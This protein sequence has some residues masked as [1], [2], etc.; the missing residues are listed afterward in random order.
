MAVVQV[1][2][3][4]LIRHSVPENFLVSSDGRPVIAASFLIQLRQCKVDLTCPLLR[5]YTLQL[6]D[7]TFHNFDINISKYL[8]VSA[9]KNFFAF[10][11]A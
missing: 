4:Q 8:T 5:T 2:T 10:K 9:Y 11:T 6:T 3:G 1:I 7:T